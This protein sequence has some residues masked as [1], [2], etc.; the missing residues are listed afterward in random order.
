MTKPGEEEE[1]RGYTSARELRLHTDLAQIAGMFC[2]RP[3]VSG[4]TSIVSS[5]LAIHNQIAAEHP[6]YMPI[7]YKGFPY[8]RRDE[9]T[10]DAAPVTPYAVPI[11]STYKGNTSAFFVREVL[12]NAADEFGIPL[13]EKEVAAL[14]YFDNCARANAFQFRLEQGDALFMNNRTILHARTKF[15]NE[16]DDARKR[17]LMRLWLD[18]PGMS[19]DVPEIKLYEN[20]DERS[21]IDPQIGRVRAAAHYRKIPNGSV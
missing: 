3:A 21:G 12:Q 5:A 7:Y 15:R 6:H 9:Q 8:H 17:H 18:V 4:G 19:P 1:T 13:T 2:Y 11:F 20:E 14:D 16:S 10:S